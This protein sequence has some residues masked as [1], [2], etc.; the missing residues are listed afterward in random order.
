M[1]IDCLIKFVIRLNILQV[2]KVVLQ[3]VL[4]IILEG[5]PTQ[6]M[7]TFYTVIILIK[8][9]VNKNKYYYNMFL[10]KGLYKVNWMFA[11]YKCYISIELTLPKEL[12]LI[13][14]LHQKS[15]IFVINDIS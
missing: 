10:E 1:I 8:S 3:I 6:K 2:N 5:L 14:Q 4:I 11:Y 13:K 7:L 12:M 15:P 9:V